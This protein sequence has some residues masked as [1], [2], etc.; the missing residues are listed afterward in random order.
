MLKKCVLP[1]WL[2]DTAEL[3]SAYSGTG[4]QR[5]EEKV[6]S[7]ANDDHLQKLLAHVFEDAVAPPSRAQDHQCLRLASTSAPVSTET[8]QHRSTGQVTTM[9]GTPRNRRLYTRLTQSSSSLSLHHESEKTQ[10][11]VSE[12]D[13]DGWN[14]INYSS[15][16]FVCAC[17]LSELADDHMKPVLK[18]D[19]AHDI[20]YI[21]KK[22]GL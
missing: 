5:R 6:V 1:D 16:L 22:C 17:V 21:S 2:N 4:Q 13:H 7:G 14:F 20:Q 11:R 3:K 18:M 9:D 15:T 12:L 19:I 8:T 10:A